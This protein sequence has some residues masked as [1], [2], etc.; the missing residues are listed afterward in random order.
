MYL[1]RAWVSSQLASLPGHP[2]LQKLFNLWFTLSK[3]YASTSAMN[4]AV[5]TN[6][7]CFLYQEYAWGKGLHQTEPH[8]RLGPWFST[9]GGSGYKGDWEPQPLSWFPPTVSHSE[10]YRLGPLFWIGYHLPW[11]A[12]WLPMSWACSSSKEDKQASAPAFH[13]HSS[14]LLPQQHVKDAEPH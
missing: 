2:F 11:A 8:L 14:I 1:Y 5:C 12:W 10:K 13:L 3:S 7:D 4:K 9:L 6:K